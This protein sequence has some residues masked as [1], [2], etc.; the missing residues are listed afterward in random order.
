MESSSFLFPNVDISCNTVIQKVHFFVLYYK[1]GIFNF[2]N[3]MLP[4]QGNV[5]VAV[6]CFYLKHYNYNAYIVQ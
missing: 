3:D 6:F 5:Q 4:K 2:K 1:T